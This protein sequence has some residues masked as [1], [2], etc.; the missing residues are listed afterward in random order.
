MGLTLEL[1]VISTDLRASWTWF[2]VDC[3]GSDGERV[4]DDDM[5]GEK[6]EME[7]GWR[8]VC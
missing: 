2:R 3:D 1:D 5:L 4:E 6:G 7:G 8:V